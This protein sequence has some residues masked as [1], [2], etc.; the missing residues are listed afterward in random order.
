MLTNNTWHVFTGRWEKKN[1]R[2]TVRHITS[3]NIPCLSSLILGKIVVFF[4]DLHTESELY[5]QKKKI[6][7]PEDLNPYFLNL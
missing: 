2:I 6:K 5:K 1:R 4:N 3:V 7:L